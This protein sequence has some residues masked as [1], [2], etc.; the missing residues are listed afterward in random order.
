MI[1]AAATL[2]LAAT[3]PPGAWLPIGV[4]DSRLRIFV[5]RDSL[6][7]YG[8]RRVARIRIGSPGTITGS[9]V[10]VYQ[11]EAIDCR[12]R[13]WRL[14]AFDARDA[15]GRVVKR[16]AVDKPT[17]PVVAGTIGA[18]VVSAVCAMPATP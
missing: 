1:A 17:L 12:A 14:V 2:L 7:V 4:S 3:D 9:I 10:L 16:G 15:D 6:R 18:A 11:D 5:Q 8:D 13:S